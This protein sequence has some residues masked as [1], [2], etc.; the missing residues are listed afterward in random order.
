MLRETF[1]CLSRHDVQLYSKP[2]IVL[3]LSYFTFTSDVWFSLSHL[4][5]GPTSEA[6]LLQ[7]ERGEKSSYMAPLL[8]PMHSTND[9]TCFGHCKAT[10]AGEARHLNGIQHR[11]HWNCRG[12]YGGAASFLLR[13]GRM[14]R[15]ERAAA[16][17]TCY[18][19][20]APQ[21]KMG[22]G[23]QCPESR[24][25]GMGPRIFHFATLGNV[26][27]MGDSTVYGGPSDLRTAAVV[28]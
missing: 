26:V 4:V 20:S 22:V 3:L 2:W 13:M 23:P 6:L 17:W 8:Q 7:R 10:A 11:P 5:D 9:F 19:V 18:W 15:L 16:S 25:W 27:M 14:M 24:G 21:E 28:A 12:G 1:A